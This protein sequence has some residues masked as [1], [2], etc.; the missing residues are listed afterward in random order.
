MLS[1][2]FAKVKK[3]NTIKDSPGTVGTA[4]ELGDRS[5]SPPRLHS[6]LLNVNKRLLAPGT[7]VRLAGFSKKRAAYN[8]QE[9]KIVEFKAS[10]D[11]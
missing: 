11:R 10:I 3:Q 6:P 7:P 2:L 9:G 5:P 4:F 1:E 8:G